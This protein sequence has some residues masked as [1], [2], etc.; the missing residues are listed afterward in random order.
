MS[1]ASEASKLI[2]NKYFLYF[3]VF[4]AA[5]N[6]LGYLV[7]NKM[8]AVIF[9]ALVSLLTYQFSKNMSV[10]LLVAII[11]TNFLMA[12]KRI[13]E[14]LENE[15]TTSTSQTTSATPTTSTSQT[16]SATP[17]TSTTQTTPALNNIE[18][19]DQE[20]AN[21]IGPVKKS[22]SNT[23]VPKN[24]LA[25][26][27]DISGDQT[28]PTKMVD[29]NN[30]GLNN[31][32]NDSGPVAAGETLQGSKN[33]TTNG[34][35]RIDY[36]TTIEKSYEN[37]DKILG[38]DSINKLTGDTQRLMSQQQ[39]LFDTMQNM[40]P[41]IEGAKGMLDKLNIGNLTDSLTKMNFGGSPVVETNK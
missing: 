38:S 27:N 36:S 16:T 5:T 41:M 15:S 10:I 34:G 30:E 2:T 28:S 12:N 26:S 21:A 35:P 32:S 40:V 33:K 39:K 9:F 22:A 1:L 13:R 23:E 6:I 7:T 3:M 24:I 29:V 17:T 25:T 4:L 8:N 20:I 11:A 31:M 19:K 18:A 37:L 14:G